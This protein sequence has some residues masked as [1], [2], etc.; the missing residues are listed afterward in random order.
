MQT[1]V[2]PIKLTSIRVL[3]PFGDSK[4]KV[5]TGGT[6]PSVRTRIPRVGSKETTRGVPEFTLKAT[7]GYEVLM[8]R[9]RTRSL[10]A[11]SGTPTVHAL[12]EAAFAIVQSQSLP[13]VNPKHQSVVL[14]CRNTMLTISLR[15]I[16]T[17]R[18]CW[19]CVESAC[20]ALMTRRRSRVSR[21]DGAAMT[22]RI[23]RTTIVMSSS[24]RVKPDR[25]G[26][27]MVAIASGICNLFQS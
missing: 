11:G 3:T 12:G 21:N 7:A 14:V 5:S 16:A 20:V 8:V 15:A 10:D 23:T 9:I 22:S 1:D 6:E 27:V 26:L 13:S 18:A 2:R 4:V 19:I 24:I 17:E 25:L